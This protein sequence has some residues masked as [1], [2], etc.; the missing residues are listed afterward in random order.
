MIHIG[1]IC[2]TYDADFDKIVNEL[3]QKFDEIEKDKKQL[4][5]EREKFSNEK[6]LNQ[7]IYESD[8]IH[9]NVDGEMIA[10]TRQTLISLPKSLFSILFNGHW[11]QRLHH[12][13]HDNI[14]L[15]FNPIVFRHLLDQLRLNDGKSISP[16][17]D[18]SL[19]RSFEKMMRKLRIESLLSTSDRNILTVNVDGQLITTHLSNSSKLTSKTH[20]FIDRH[21]KVFR[22]FIKINRQNKSFSIDKQIFYTSTGFSHKCITF[23]QFF[24]FLRQKYFCCNETTRKY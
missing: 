7:T 21:P 22:H 16:P 11:E 10:T 17:S 24:C 8:V 1:H 15:D 18:S 3:R 2:G 14:F 6:E 20:V 4:E 9:L 12:D 5:V 23:L 13:N 19:I